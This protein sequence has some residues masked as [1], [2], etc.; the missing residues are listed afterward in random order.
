[1]FIA[2]VTRGFTLPELMVV[3]LIIGL[4][5]AAAGIRFSGVTQNAKLEWAS[6]QIRSTDEQL[7]RFAS[8]DGAKGILKIDLNDNQLIRVYQD[9]IDQELKIDL[10]ETVTI[11]RFLSRTRDLKYNEAQVHYTQGGVTESFAL[12][13]GLPSG[14]SVWLCVAGLTGRITEE[15][16]TENVQELFRKLP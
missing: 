2:K 4:I 5:A 3:I 1:M 16:Q 12:E 14:K 6:Q 11:K 8:R 10:G 7:R 13:L 9:K 15:E